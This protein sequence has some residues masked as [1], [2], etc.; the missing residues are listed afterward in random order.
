VHF[1]F[2]FQNILGWGCVHR[3]SQMMMAEAMQRLALVFVKFSCTI[4]RF[5][6][7]LFYSII[8]LENTALNIPVT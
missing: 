1:S 7:L 2:F 5:N 3:T 8:N 6:N 4:I